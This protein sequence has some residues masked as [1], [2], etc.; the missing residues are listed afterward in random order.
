MA[1]TADRF[2][3]GSPQ[4]PQREPNPQ[5]GDLSKALG[6]AAEAGKQEYDE[7]EVNPEYQGEIAADDAGGTRMAESAGRSLERERKDSLPK[8]PPDEASG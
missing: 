7:E 5:K 8:P 1:S 6:A 4:N 3:E 2:A